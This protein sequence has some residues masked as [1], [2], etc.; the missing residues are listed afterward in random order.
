MKTFD[1]EVVRPQ[2]EALEN[3]P[4]YAAL[5]SL[6]DLRLFMNHHVFSVWDF[7]SLIKYL[8]NAV[9]PTR[10]P[11]TPQGDAEARYFINQLCLEEESDE[12]ELPDGSVRHA[13][14]F[15]SYCE[16]MA[17]IGA[18]ADLPRRFVKAVDERGVA[19]ALADPTVPEPS[20]RFTHSTFD[21]IASGK[22]HAVAAV[23]ALGREQIIPGMFRRFLSDM[24]I[25]ARDAPSFHFY[26][27]RHIHL[28]EDFHGP[29]SIRLV[30]A[31]CGGEQARIHEAEEAA[32]AALTARITFWDG[33][34]EAIE[35][36]RHAA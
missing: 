4:I 1:P 20:R 7:M 15:E 17:E 27:N 11:W 35:A 16:A 23:L 5:R 30:N 22:P 8:Q 29:L 24:A 2:Q 14:H 31:L 25:T 32:R 18:D 9:A 19:L 34:L 21:F 36:R 10:V 13:S 26:L 28:D 12:I 6:D 3:H 33:V